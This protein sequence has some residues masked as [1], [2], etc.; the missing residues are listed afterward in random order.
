MLSGKIPCGIYGNI[1][2]ITVYFHAKMSRG[3]C[4]LDTDGTKTDDTELLSCESRSRQTV[5]FCFSASFPTFSLSFSWS[6]PSSTPPTI[7][8]AARS[9]P[10]ITSSLTPFALAPGVL[11]TTIPCSA[12]S[13]NGMLLTPAPARAIALTCFPVI[14]SHASKRFLPESHPL[15][16]ISSVFV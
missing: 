14:P 12:Q 15:L 3:V 13:C 7:S 10:A 6:L 1:R 11:N 8:R 16:S 4:Y 9:I 2:I 5:F